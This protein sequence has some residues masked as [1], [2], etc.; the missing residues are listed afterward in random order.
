[1][2]FVNKEMFEDK[3]GVYRITNTVTG[4]YYTGKTVRF[5][6]RYKGHLKTIKDPYNSVGNARMRHAA[7]LYPPS[8]FVFEVIAVTPNAAVAL[9]IESH[10]L[11]G[12]LK[13]YYNVAESNDKDMR[14]CSQT[15]IPVIQYSSEGN[16]I[17]IFASATEASKEVGVSSSVIGKCIAGY[18]SHNTAGGFVWKKYINCEEPSYFIEPVE[19]GGR[20]GEPMKEFWNKG[21]YIIKEYSLKGEYIKSWTDIKELVS[22]K[23]VTFRM[24][25]R[26]LSGMYVTCMGSVFTLD[27]QELV[28]SDKRRNLPILKCTED[29]TI[30][31][32]YVTA[33]YA[34]TQEGISYFSI[35]DALNLRYRTN[36]AGKF[37]WKYD[38]GLPFE[39]HRADNN[40]R[41]VRTLDKNGNTLKEF[42]SMSDMIKESG[43]SACT[44]YKYIKNGTMLSN[45]GYDVEYL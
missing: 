27:D 7:T 10:F 33:K 8:T 24:F 26:H 30:L 22:D 35:W 16:L 13:G 6:D 40:K 45:V 11:K 28:L 42:K 32:S 21:T 43:F 41:K 12:K 31:Q 3:C 1:M 14:L 2:E 20:T 34:A 38:D 25:T 23:G 5:G 37:F 29:G 15:S 44:I 9:Q 39:A 17:K 4:D 36:K 19:V 18:P